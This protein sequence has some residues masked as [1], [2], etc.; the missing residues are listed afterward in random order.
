MTHARR[1]RRKPGLTFREVCAIGRS[2]PDVEEGTWYGTP[3]L[4]LRGKGL[5][6]LREDGETMAVRV[7]FL[8]REELLH[9]DPEAFFVTDHY[10]HYPAVVVRLAKVRRDVMKRVLTLACEM[11]GSGKRRGDPTRRRTRGP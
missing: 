6:R 3:A 1:S 4:K 7:D 2:L 10:L 5:A 8:E 9:S 11:V